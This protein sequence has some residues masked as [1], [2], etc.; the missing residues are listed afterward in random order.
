MWKRCRQATAF[1]LML[2]LI[3]GAFSFARAEETSPIV[4]PQIPYNSQRLYRDC[5]AIAERYSG[6]V[7]LESVGLSVMG[8]DIPLLKLG[9]GKRPL[10][11]IG[12]LHA[13]EAVTTGFLMQT[14][15]S[16]ADA[17]V[18]KTAFG[19][20]TAEKVRWLLDEFTVY[21][22][23]MA[24]P[25]GVDIVTAGGAA[26]V[27][28]G[29]SATW[30]SNANGVNLNR[31]FP[32]DWDSYRPTTNPNTNNHLSYTGSSAGSEP[33]TQALITLCESVR[34]EHMV[35]CHAQGK[36][37][38][39][40][41]DKN[42]VIPGDLS[43]ARTLSQLTGFGIMPS[44]HSA[45]GGW[46]GG[47]EN[48]F[49]HQYGKPGICMEFCYRNTADNDTMSRFY[50]QNMIDWDRS[51]NLLFGVMDS[52][53]DIKAVPMAVPGL[54]NGREIVF[55]AY[56]I[57][58]EHFFKLIDIMYILSGTEKQFSFELD[59]TTNTINLL[60]GAAYKPDGSEMQS[61]GTETVTPNPTK[62]RLLLDGVPIDV[63][64]CNM[65][66]RNYFKIKDVAD[67]FGFDALWIDSTLV[68]D[69]R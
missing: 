63:K 21:I 42:G 55:Q 11:W 48:W 64:S 8:R 27:Y 22:V 61:L 3:M 36:V 40:R 12:A 39:Y 62:S 41:D 17:Y 51:K 29:D 46:A 31:N 58:G 4:N 54:I 68:L 19:K 57:A 45:A 59:L 9:R 53:S 23:P 49:R 14:I 15:E 37:V 47:F 16:Y 20:T 26:T 43:L 6:I 60:S 24:N 69:T 66:Y 38:Y 65:K 5:A 28:V 34:F 7:S 13:R 52:L 18:N 25:D 56:R 67:L 35:S 30:K 50:T 33:E 44:T 1:M 10:L 2:V 32:F